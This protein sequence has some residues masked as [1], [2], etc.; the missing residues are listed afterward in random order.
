MAYAG[1]SLSESELLEG[2]Q[3]EKARLARDSALPRKKISESSEKSTEQPQS[4]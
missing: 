3:E 4:S 1:A 2:I